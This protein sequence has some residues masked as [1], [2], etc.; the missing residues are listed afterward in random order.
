MEIDVIEHVV[1]V[2]PTTIGDEAMAAA[3]IGLVHHMT[4]ADQRIDSVAPTTAHRSSRTASL[5]SSIDGKKLS[6]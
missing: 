2:V 6:M 1:E 5:V 3:I 4:E